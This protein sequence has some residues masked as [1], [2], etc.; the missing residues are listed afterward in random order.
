MSLKHSGSVCDDKMMKRV[1]DVLS[2]A[3]RCV[4]MVFVSQGEDCNPDVG[5][6][7]TVVSSVTQDAGLGIESDGAA[8]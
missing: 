3:L 5:V 1:C 8:L 7:H 4:L 2:V 6:T